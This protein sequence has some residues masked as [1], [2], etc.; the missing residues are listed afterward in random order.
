[1]NDKVKVD[2]IEDRVFERDGIKVV[3][4]KL[5]LR[6][7]RYSVFVGVDKG[8]HVSRFMPL[9]SSGQGR[10]TVDRISNTVAELLL[11][12]EEY[13]QGELQYLEDTKIERVQDREFTHLMKEKPRGRRGLSGGP[14]SGKTARKRANRQKRMKEERAE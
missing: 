3:V 6:W 7:P 8:E 9:R 2:W 4:Q 12:A 1:M 13:V 5:P 14:G 11:E 10:I